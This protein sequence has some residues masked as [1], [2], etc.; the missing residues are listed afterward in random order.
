[1]RGGRCRLK[2]WVTFNS[3][4]KPLR[5]LG[6]CPAPASERRPPAA[7]C[8]REPVELHDKLGVVSRRSPGRGRSPPWRGL[9]GTSSE[10]QTTETFQRRWRLKLRS[11]IGS[12]ASRPRVSHGVRST[13]RVDLLARMRQWAL[14]IPSQGTRVQNQPRERSQKRRGGDPGN[15]RD[16]ASRAPTGAR[17]ARRERRRRPTR[18]PTSARAVRRERRRTRART[19]MRPSRVGSMTSRDCARERPWTG[20]TAC[21]EI[22]G[23]ERPIRSP[24]PAKR[25]EG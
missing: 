3:E 5:V 13:R 1:M 2:R 4:G 14:K 16:Q 23:R 22:E 17:T 7:A 8:L 9:R 18:A 12:E 20:A 10:A 15:T 19:V 21:R 25:G 11:K 24:L 6:S